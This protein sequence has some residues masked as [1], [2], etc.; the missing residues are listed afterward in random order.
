MLMNPS[1]SLKSG[2]T[3]RFLSW[4]T[5]MLMGY[6]LLGR[7]FSYFGVAPLYMG[8]ISLIFGFLALL[9]NRSTRHFFNDL[10]PN[11][12]RVPAAA[13]L[14]LFIG[15]CIACTIPYIPVYSLDAIRDSAT[16]YYSLFAILIALFLLH[17]PEHLYLL[18][19]RYRT[20][21]IIFLALTPFLWVITGLKIM[22]TL[23][24]A[25]AAILESKIADI[26][27]HLAGCLAFAVSFR[28]QQ[29]G[30]IGFLFLLNLAAVG[31]GTNRSG[32]VAF[33]IAALIVVVLYPRSKKVWLV[34]GA[35]GVALLVI[36]TFY[37]ETVAPF[38]SKLSSIISSEGSSARDEGT[39][40]WRLLWW[41]KI[42]NYTFHGQYFWTGRGFGI[43]L[44]TVD[45]FD[46][47]QDGA[48]RSPHN[49]HM[50]ILARTGVPGFMLWIGM[51]ASWFLGCLAFYV[52]SLTQGQKA[53]SSLFLFLMIYW[54]AF[55]ITTT[56]EVIIEGPT[57]GLW[58]WTVF[59]VGMAAQWLYPRMPELLDG[60]P[61]PMLEA[62]GLGEV[63]EVG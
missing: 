32:A 14:L 5:W 61:E 43:N 12:L 31:S 30:L 29:V 2:L 16:W 59:G 26:M 39:K 18:L 41:N 10:L 36:L 51:H 34:I 60:E 13:I 19:S 50:T 22:P 62:V 35:I 52:K 55:M 4:Q 47:F 8:E 57:G 3:G 6:A 17:K 56:F 23:P 33:T 15:W 49:G 48:L 63:G 44:A 27:V 58:I 38:F 54:M 21:V 11:L 20:F 7:G 40:E 53:W 46:P 1:F 28:L 37:P 24:G 25:K 45:G 9:F 42:I